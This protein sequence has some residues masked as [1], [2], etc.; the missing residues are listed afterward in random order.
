MAKQKLTVY[1]DHHIER[2][3]LFY[4]RPS[5]A[6]SETQST[7]DFLNIKQLYGDQSESY[8][9]R[10]PDFQRATWSWTPEDCVELLEAVLNEQVV[11][12][13]IMWLDKDGTKF[14]LDGGH[15]ISVLLAWISDD[16]GDRLPAGHFKDDTLE[17]A[18]KT[19]AMR[20]RDLLDQRLIG[21]F[22][23]YLLAERRHRELV[24]KDRAPGAEMDSVSLEYAQKV[25][26]WASVDIG[27]PVLW[28]KG[29]Y[30]TAEQSFLKINKTG[31]QL[32]KWE[33]K[34]V[35]NRT[36]SM[37]RAVMSIAEVQQASRF[38]PLD[39]KAIEKSKQLSE[40][41]QA[42]IERVKSLHELL[43]LPVYETP[44]RQ[45]QQ[46]LVA[47]P[48]TKPE[49]K[50][51]Y[52]A[53]VLTI[54]EGLKGQPAETDKL[55]QRDSGASSPELVEHG[56]VLLNHAWDDLSS[57]YGASPRSLSMMP[58]VY[59][60]SDQG[61][62]VR[63]LL[64]GM[65]Y[66]MNYGAQKEIFDRR[67]IFT[68]HRRAFEGIILTRKE[69][70]ITRIA[71]RIGSGYEVTYPT[72]RYYHG[73]L[74]LLI[75]HDDVTDST[76]FAADHKQLIET[77]GKKDVASAPR[78]PESTRPTFT[79]TQKTTVNVGE[80]IEMF[81]ECEIC[82]GRYY[83][84]LFTQADHI[85]PRSKGGKTAVWNA[86]NTHPFCNNNRDKIDQVLNKAIAIELPA[87]NDSDE[88][89]QLSFL[90]FGS[91]MESEETDGLGD[92]DDAILTE[93]SEEDN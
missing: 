43:F 4:R 9:L 10:K 50:P 57:I 74:K 45:P 19:A 12:S 7:R 15:R 32:S 66:W 28:V 40:K 35:E 8:L 83:P 22:Q 30:K 59:F 17:L 27:F 14:V 2:D 33:T 84:G 21:S 31:R 85:E 88:P 89:I 34:L 76:G 3:S 62:Y 61:R 92:E 49:A 36:S 6:G 16:W 91:D 44:I 73:L 41:A 29:D 67:L 93:R 37:A 24:Q 25:R 70:I 46:P 47:T 20:V 39:D 72:A 69:E 60:Y 54:T 86:R 56:L 90:D 68:V 63:S 5:T 52:V 75:K 53:E 82:G 80:Y 78:K 38:W 71:R 77:L 58:L 64:Y 55:I 26:R 65:L 48:F 79:R 23:D 51:A 87:F 1:L 18:S 13:V 81:R 42:I 11:P